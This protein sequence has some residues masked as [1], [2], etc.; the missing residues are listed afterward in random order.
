MS[1]IRG[2]NPSIIV[3]DDSYA[4]R[5]MFIDQTGRVVEEKL[6]VGSKWGSTGRC[7]K[8]VYFSRVGA[9]LPKA[10]GH[11]KWDKHGLANERKNC[12]MSV[13]VEVKDEE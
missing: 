5:G 10:D 6:V 9:M 4:G 12:S 7:R 1:K 11:C 13:F 8:C 2:Y 3:H